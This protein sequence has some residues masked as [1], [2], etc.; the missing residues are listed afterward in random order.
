MLSG[1]TGQGVEL[2]P[3]S[4]YIGERCVALIHI[5]ALIS[6]NP[7]RGSAISGVK[8][9]QLVKKR[10]WTSAVQGKPC[11]HNPSKFRETTSEGAE[12]P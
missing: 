2:S 5:T 8:G 6:G 11:I 1:W 9:W 7:E 3:F 4:E 10:V 12:L